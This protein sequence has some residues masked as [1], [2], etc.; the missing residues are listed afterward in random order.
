MLLPPRSTPRSTREGERH[1][2][3]Q[4]RR[5]TQPTHEWQLLLPLFEWPEQERYEQI[6][7]LVLFDASVAERAAEVGTSA[8]TLYRRLDRFAKEGMETLFDAPA[9]KRNRLPPA[10]R[11]L[12]V[13][14]KAEYPAFNLNEI[15]NVV[16][17]CFGTQTGRTARWR[18]CS[19]RSPCR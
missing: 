11:R 4:A 19:T 13:D 2:H 17:A 6:R 9:A 1:G 10:V 16:H 8:S 15:A 7:P 14:L 5:R 3:E 18:A 12:I